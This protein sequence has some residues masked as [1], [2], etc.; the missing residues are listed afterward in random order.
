MSNPILIKTAVDMIGLPC[1]PV[2][3]PMTAPTDT[4]RTSLSCILH[5]MGVPATLERTA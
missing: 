3:P 1:G 2:R 5:A 4:E